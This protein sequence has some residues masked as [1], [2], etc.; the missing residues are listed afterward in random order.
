[1]TLQDLCA[2][3]V[4]APFRPPELMDVPSTIEI[5]E[6][7]DSWS[8]GCTIYAIAFGQSPCKNTNN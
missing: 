4:T 3:T 6:R 7:T 1:M 2:E 8:L 5:D